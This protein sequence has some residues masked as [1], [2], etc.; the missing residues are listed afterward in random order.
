VVLLAGVAGA[1]WLVGVAAAHADPIAGPAQDSENVSG[2]VPASTSNTG[3]VAAVPEQ[4]ALAPVNQLESATAPTADAPGELW[5]TVSGNDAAKAKHTVAASADT[6]TGGTDDGALLS[7]T[8]S[9]LFAPAGAGNSNVTA[10]DGFGSVPSLV[11]PVT[12]SLAGM[13]SPITSSLHPAAEPV[14]GRLG[15]TTVPVVTTLTGL[16]RPAVAAA[17]PVG[18]MLMPTAS[19]PARSGMSPRLITSVGAAGVHPA[20][21]HENPVNRAAPVRDQVN[22]FTASAEHGQT[23]SNGMKAE[24]PNWS[25]DVNRRD[26]GQ[27]PIRDVAFPDPGIVA[28]GNTTTGAS[29]AGCSPYDSGA[30]RCASDHAGR[31]AQVSR[32][33]PLTATM[34]HLPDHVEDPAVSPD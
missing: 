3:T 21:Q 26:R 2:L 22:G 25:G 9:E 14:N 34:D 12:D 24:T 18:A 10:S 16:T 29:S 30:G 33:T 31:N 27:E 1:A 6:A 13:T 20:G 4:A 23:A 5:N 11:A 15:S 32:V 17:D 28:T 8:V 7:T 19:A